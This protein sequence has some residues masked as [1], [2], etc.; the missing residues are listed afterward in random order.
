[1]ICIALQTHDKLFNITLSCLLSIRAVP[2]CPLNVLLRDLELGKLF[3]L[4]IVGT[5]LCLK[6]VIY[7]SLCHQ[8]DITE[9]KRSSLQALGISILLLYHYIASH[10]AGK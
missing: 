6:Q 7:F 2:N 5:T 1:M 4:L 9:E 8:Y 3:L 10:M